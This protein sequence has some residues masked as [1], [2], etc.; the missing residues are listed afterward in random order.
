MEARGVFPRHR[1]GQTGLMGVTGNGSGS[2]YF[3]QWP[4]RPNN[5][6]PRIAQD[7]RRFRLRD[8]VP[9]LCTR[10]V[11]IVERLRLEETRIHRCATDARPVNL[12]LGL[13]LCSRPSL[14]LLS[15]RESVK[16][17]EIE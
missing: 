1:D 14:T 11:I 9:R 13:P 5:Y 10:P 8:T 2:L 7:A 16:I 3:I 15:A 12:R 17:D 6:R 4:Q